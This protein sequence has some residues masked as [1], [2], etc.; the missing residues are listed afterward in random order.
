MPLVKSDDLGKD[1]SAA[2]SLLQRHIRLEE[3]I[4]AYRSD[5]IRLEEMSAQLASSSFHS[6]TTSTHQ[7]CKTTEDVTVPQI[8]MLYKYEGN[9]MIVSKGEILALLEQS[10]PEWWRVL[11]Q[12]GTEG[13]V[14]ANYCR[15]V[16]GETVS[17]FVSKYEELVT[18]TQT[19]DTK[20]SNE[21]TEG[22]RVIVD[23]QNMISFDYRQLNNLAEVRR[24]LLSDNI[25]LMR[26]VFSCCFFFNY[27]FIAGQEMFESALHDVLC[28][29]E[30]TKKLL[31]E[32]TRA[33]D[34]QQAG[35]LL[36][37]HFD[38]GEQIED[39]KYEVGFYF[40]YE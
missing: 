21:V 25:K 4:H 20:T 35:E 11:K 37:K 2:E 34:V 7:V 27:F 9:G 17:I 1:E 3:E 14:P 40:V 12:D 36:K 33:V 19:T 6:A 31:A 10:T 39:K 5:I 29:I 38:L 32:D 23:R 24:R 16:I 22:K 26:F 18:V 8:E 15:T 30:R 13:F 28:W